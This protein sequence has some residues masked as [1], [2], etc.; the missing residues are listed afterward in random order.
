MELQ[1]LE[2]VLSLILEKAMQATCT[3]LDPK[4]LDQQVVDLLRPAGSL[5]VLRLNCHADVHRDL[6]V[7]L[8]LADEGLISHRV[9]EA[10]VGVDVVGRGR[11][12]GGKDIPVGTET[13]RW[14][15]MFL[16]SASSGLTASRS[17]RCTDST[18]SLAGTAPTSGTGWM[19][20]TVQRQQRRKPLR[21]RGS[22]RHHCRKC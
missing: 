6:E 1:W 19:P 15:S 3:H 22:C 5:D 14:H 4:H 21:H 10:F 16:S 20:N 18:S 9:D 7:I 17:C 13:L 11:P 12:G 2:E 8:L